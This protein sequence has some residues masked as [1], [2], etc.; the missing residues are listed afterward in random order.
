MLLAYT[1][2]AAD[3]VPVLNA[4][5]VRQRFGF[6]ENYIDVTSFTPAEAK[7]FIAELFAL[8]RPK[9][10]NVNEI[11]MR[12]AKDTNETVSAEFYPFSLEAIEAMLTKISASGEYLCPRTI[13]MTLTMSIG[14]ALI[15]E[16]PPTVITSDLIL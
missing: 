5:P 10:V 12:A 13:E 16:K 6:P 11:S 1:A 2:A 15:Q 9:G 4:L 3:A 14:D 7:E 8:L